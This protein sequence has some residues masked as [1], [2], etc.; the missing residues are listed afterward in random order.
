MK[1]IKF[2]FITFV[3]IG[4]LTI[5]NCNGQQLPQYTQWAT[6]QFSFNPAHAGIKPCVDIQTLARYQWTTVSG[7]PRSGFATLSV[8]LHAGRSD[9]LS[10]RHGIGAKVEYDHIGQ[11]ITNKVNLAYAGHFNFSRDTRLSLGMY[12]GFLHF[13]YNP[14]N[15]ITIDPDP[16]VLS[17]VSRII[18]DA[19]FGSWWN[20]RNYYFGLSI[21]NL[22]RG[23]WKGI[24]MDSRYRW[25]TYIDA[26][27]RQ[28]ISSEVTL[29]PSIL[30]KIPTR[31]PVSFDFN[32]MYDYNNVVGFG[33]G[34]RY[35]DALLG[36]FYIKLNQQLHI[37]Y[38]VDYVISPLAKG[39]SHEVS[40]NFATCKP[41]ITGTTKTAL[42]E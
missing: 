37:Q 7:A 31:G 25:Q 24:G 30:F 13:G 17:E 8:P 20:G 6:H 1:K 40:I 29:L 11:F 22:L 32:L 35:I 10:A 23:K 28:K 3:L 21:Q 9:Y 38:S 12:A 15:S 14:K 5:F 34:Y 26:G 19:T 42:F 4:N 27:Y 41:R 2:I 36:F 33:V 39:M 16:I 18:P